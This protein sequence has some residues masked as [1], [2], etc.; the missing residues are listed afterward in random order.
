[1]LRALSIGRIFGIRLDVHTSWFVIYALVSWTIANDAPVA[2]LGRVH[3]LTIGALAA[4][5]LFASV[6]IHELAHALVA[7]AFG[8]E[9]RSI[10]L[11]LFGGVATLERE[12][13]R[14]SVDALVALAGPFVSAL[15]AGIAYAALH[16]VDRV[17][18]GAAA[19]AAAAVLAYTI[20]INAMLAVFNLIPAYPMDGGRALRALLW[21]VRGDRDGATVSAALVGIGLAAVFAVA[22]IVAAV[23]TRTWQ[24]GWYVLLAGFLMRQCWQQ[25]RALRGVRGA[26][27][28][29][30]RPAAAS[31]APG[32]APAL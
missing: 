17:F 32:G 8:I 18:V 2:A 26:P 25:Y 11:F 30:L 31:V 14:P 28:V 7:R 22:G 1:M 12:P 19:D 23:A 29:A 9:T 16:G 20:W 10:A 21:W 24:F 4:L 15:L 5:A 3:A 13:A 27:V 6:V